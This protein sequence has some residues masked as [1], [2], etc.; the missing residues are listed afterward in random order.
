MKS[1]QFQLILFCFCLI[2]ITF[3]C[4]KA[5]LQRSTV[6]DDKKITERW[7]DECGDC[8][9]IADC[10][11][12]I[13]L[14]S[15][16][17]ITFETCGTADGDAAA[18]SDEIMGCLEIDGLKNSSTTLFEEDRLLF[19]MEENH[20]FLVKVSFVSTGGVVLNITCQ[21]GALSPQ[22]INVPITSIGTYA[23]SVN[24]DCEISVC[25]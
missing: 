6:L 9:N 20:S 17:S 16:T 8:P 11:C 10:C 7:V 25:P 2:V 23:F 24:D 21:V 13:T 12:A 14:V 5:D 19:C 1:N 3:S 22:S 15:G 18:C 4:E